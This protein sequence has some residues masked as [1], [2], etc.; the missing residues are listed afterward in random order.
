MTQ[1]DVEVTRRARCEITR[2]YVDSSRLDVS[3]IHGV[4]YLRGCL[5]PLRGYGD[6]DLQHEVEVISQVLSRLPNIRQV[7][8]EAEL[9]RM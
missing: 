3:V 5:R 2:R 8:W 9:A 1:S 4:V 6:V 7:V